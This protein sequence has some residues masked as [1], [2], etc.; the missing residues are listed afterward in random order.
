MKGQ[1]VQEKYFLNPNDQ[2]AIPMQK[3]TLYPETDDTTEY[4]ISFFCMT[5]HTR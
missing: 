3:L 4:K 1:L 5:G 2:C